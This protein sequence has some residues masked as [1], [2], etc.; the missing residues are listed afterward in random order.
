MIA[1][2]ALRVEGLSAGYDRLTVVRNI[3]LSVNPGEVLAIL[4]PNGS[5][6]TTL[7]MTIAGFLKPQAGL[8]Q[9][10]GVALP[11]GSPRKMNQAGVILVPDKRALFTQLTPVEN[12]QLAS[13]SGQSKV[14]EIL[15]LF[16]ALGARARIRAG[17]LSGGEQ[18]MLALSRALVQEPKM[19]LVDEMS[20]GLAPAIVESLMPLIR[21][22]AD[23][24]GAA[25]ML[26]EQ[27]VQ[28]ALETA[29]QAAVLVHGEIV[30]A[31]PA[32]QLRADPGRLEAAY[33]GRA[34]APA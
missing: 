16:P 33:M 3:H 17:Q 32:E 14:E 5:G 12:L 7:L 2:P 30:A 28:L 27:H 10:N 22:I 4:G 25:V 29:D 34:S 19:L 18:Q 8:I 31:G 26:V 1:A 21:R 9:V 23:E 20:M 15:E 24:T 11:P 13:R 6:K